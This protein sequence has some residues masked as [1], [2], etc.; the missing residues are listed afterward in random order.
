MLLRLDVS[1]SIEASRVP[2]QGRAARG[3][4][5]TLVLATIAE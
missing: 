3:F 2:G 1:R 4:C 5:G